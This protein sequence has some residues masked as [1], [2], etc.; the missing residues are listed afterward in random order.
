MMIFKRR[1]TA[2]KVESVQDRAKKTDNTSQLK[3]DEIHGH[4]HKRYR[5]RDETKEGTER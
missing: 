3:S 1:P 2:K 5:R 4:A